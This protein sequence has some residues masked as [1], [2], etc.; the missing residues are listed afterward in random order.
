MSTY[1]IKCTQGHDVNGNRTV[2]V[3]TSKGGRSLMGRELPA[4]HRRQ[5]EAN[6]AYETANLNAAVELLAQRF[7]LPDEYS[8]PRL[9]EA[10]GPEGAVWLIF[11]D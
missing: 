9:H 1:V 3:E 4:R 7:N 11:Q 6:E 2:A 5:V 10:N 8:R